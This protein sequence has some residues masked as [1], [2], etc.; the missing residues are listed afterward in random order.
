MNQEP[1]WTPPAGE[2]IEQ[3]IAA[4]KWKDAT[5]YQDAPHSY[6]IRD[7]DPVL[8]AYF[9]EKLKTEARREQFT[10]RGKTYWYR[11]YYPGDG[12]RY[13]IIKHVLNRCVADQSRDRDAA[14][15]DAG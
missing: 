3:R 8:F 9:E 1:L 6:I 14:P 11:Y 7:W 13:W 15:G 10:L 2:T 4:T 5:T 12:Y